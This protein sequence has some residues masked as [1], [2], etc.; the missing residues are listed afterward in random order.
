[1][2]F[3]YLVRPFAERII[4]LDIINEIFSFDTI[5]KKGDLKKFNRNN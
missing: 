5:N 2:I 3:T 4:K 1:M